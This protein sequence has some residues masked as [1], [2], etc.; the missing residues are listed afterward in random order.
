MKNSG[1]IEDS[2][3]EY[4]NL[5]VYVT[6]KDQSIRLC[7]DS[8]K[9]NTY[10]VADREGPERTD[11]IFQKFV[12]TKYF[13]SLDL[14]CRFLQVE[15]DKDS[16]KYVAF[17]FGGKNYVFKRLPFGTN[18]ST[19]MFVKAMNHIFGP[20]FNSFLTIYVD[21]ILITSQTPDEHLDHIEIVLSRLG[22]CGTTVKLKKSEFFK[23]E[24][25]FLGFIIS[26]K[27]MEENPEKL[28]KNQRVSRA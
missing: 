23:R 11:E 10:L 5:L 14:S 26:D 13:T 6:K 7:L 1:I 4:T 8:M 16:R 17:T 18:I 3:S 27:G 25:K 21:N 19:A 24:V 2:N 22:D 15:L 28:E 9:L 12:G 20:E